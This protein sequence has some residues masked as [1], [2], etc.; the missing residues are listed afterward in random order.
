MCLRFSIC[1]ACLFRFRSLVFIPSLFILAPKGKGKDTR[2]VTVQLPSGFFD[3]FIHGGP[4]HFHVRGKIAA[5]PW[6]IHI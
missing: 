3:Y 2:M 1:T 6:G 5:L 4:G